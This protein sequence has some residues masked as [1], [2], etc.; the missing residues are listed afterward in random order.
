VKGTLHAFEI[1]YTFDIP[2]ALVKDEVT[3]TDKAMATLASA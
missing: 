3:S 1:P 2:A